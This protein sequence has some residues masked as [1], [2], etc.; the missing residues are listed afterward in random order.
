MELLIAHSTGHVPE[1]FRQAFVTPVVK[2]QD[3]E[4]GSRRYR[5]Q[6]LSSDIELI[7]FIEAL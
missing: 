5:R 6:F 1:V 3:Q 7:G 2:T 4:A